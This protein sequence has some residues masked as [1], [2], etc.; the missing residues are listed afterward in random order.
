MMN[1][2]EAKE[3]ADQLVKMSSAAYAAASL[4]IELATENERLTKQLEMAKTE[5][6]DLE[7]QL[8]SI[9]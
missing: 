1:P 4:L 8:E 5:M 3:R 9:L 2:D 6:H 7:T